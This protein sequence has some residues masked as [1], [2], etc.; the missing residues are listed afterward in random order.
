MLVS[1][2]A[3][4]P[5]Q[6]WRSRH[7]AQGS[8]QRCRPALF[9]GD[10]DSVN[11]DADGTCLNRTPALEVS[12]EKLQTPVI[13]GTHRNL[14]FDSASSPRICVVCLRRIGDVLLTAP[15]LRSLRKAYPHAR[16]EALVFAGTDA[17]L[18]GNPD[19]DAIVA[20]PPRGGLRQILQLW[21]RYDLAVCTQSSD[22]PH[23]ISLWAARRRISVV[24]RLGEPGY[25]WKRW[26]SWRWSELPNGDAHTVVQYL[27]LAERLGIPALMQGSPPRTPDDSALV[28][29]LGANWQQRRYAVLHLAP[30][31]RYKA[32]TESNWL[33]LIAWLHAR[34]LEVMLSGGPE[35]QELQAARHLQ[36]Q[37]DGSGLHNLA[38]Q[39]QLGDLTRLIENAAVYV[40]PD[41]SITHLAAMTGTPTIALFGPSLPIIWGPWPQ[42]GIRGAASPWVEKSALQQHGNVWLLQGE[43]VCVPCGFEGCERHVQSRSLCLEELQV[44]RVTAAIT[45]ALGPQ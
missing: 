10:D 17:A 41:T 24:P 2:S 29:A 28:R 15:L 25:R 23:L 11:L 8:I 14:M 32:W 16:I 43:G 26:L 36:E 22:R 42:Q 45:A 40:G 31:F 34:G 18:A 37:L 6:T 3:D 30:K 1:D 27:R 21:R 5:P 39:L 12:V 7:S 44:Q 13:K 4:R 20:L 9:H 38:G 33:G 19:I 35:P